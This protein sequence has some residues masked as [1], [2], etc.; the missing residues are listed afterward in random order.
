MGEREEGEAEV[1]LRI[2]TSTGKSFETTV[3]PSQTVRELKEQ[4]ASA[5]EVGPEE[6]RLIYKGRA[7]KDEVAL[8]H[9]EVE[10][11][12][13]VHLVRAVRPAQVPAQ[14]ARRAEPGAAAYG[15]APPSGAPGG[16]AM[17][18]MQRRLLADPEAMMSL[19]NSPMTQSLLSN[20]EAVRSVIE[21]NPR[22]RGV[23][24]ANPQLR[25]ALSDPNLLREAF[26]VA[27]SPA[28]LREAMRHQ[29]LALSQLENHPEG[30]SALRRMYEDVQSPLLDG[31]DDMAAAPAANR[32]QH[33]QLPG[34]APSGA[35]PNPWARPA[36]RPAA[37]PFASPLASP[38]PALLAQLLSPAPAPRP[39]TQP[40]IPPNPWAHIASH[41]SD[42]ASRDPDNSPPDNRDPPPNNESQHQ[43]LVE[44][45]FLDRAANERALIAANGDVAAAINWLIA[46][47][48]RS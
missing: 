10:A 18:E 29:D 27:R 20:P 28:R 1:R 35:L 44:M 16:D 19:L 17:A 5:A 12:G 2:R 13:T 26:E 46:N 30:F 37:P 40:V 34:N 43:Q 25:H 48:P 8:S 36:P 47:P 45:G 42:T 22:L 21:S 3:R 14:A 11:Q 7:L 38:D 24:E 23:L 32:P 41:T 31:I 15:V 9:Y 6:Q 4:I 33:H 39:P